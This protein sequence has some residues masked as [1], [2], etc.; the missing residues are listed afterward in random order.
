MTCKDCVHYEVCGYH[1]TEET[2]MTINECPH[3]FKNKAD[4]EEVRHGEWVAYDLPEDDEGYGYGSGEE[5][6]TVW[7]R[8]SVC[9]E[10]ALGKCY[11][12]QWYSYP[13]RTNYC[14]SCGA[15]MDGGD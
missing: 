12:D 8:C 9:G 13:M 5:G 4:V 14:P 15:K 2:D 7:Y 10:E 3:E 6:G 11:E 1:I